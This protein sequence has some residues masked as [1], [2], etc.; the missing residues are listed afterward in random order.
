[1]SKSRV[2]MPLQLRFVLV[3]FAAIVVFLVLAPRAFPQTQSTK[4]SS[5]NVST[6]P[7]V[8]RNVVTGVANSVAP[9]FSLQVYDSGGISAGQVAVGDLN[10]DGWLDLAVADSCTITWMSCAGGGVVAVFL[11]GGGGFSGPAVYSSGGNQTG[12]VVMSDVNQDGKLDVVVYS[13]CWSVG[14]TPCLTEGVLMGNGDGSLEP[15]M[16]YSG[17]VT[18]KSVSWSDVP[19]FNGDGILDA[20]S[21][22]GPDSPG[23]TVWVQ[24]GNPD[25]TFQP[26]VGYSSGGT[27]AIAAVVVDVNGDGY[28]DILALNECPN[29]S[30]C[31]VGSV[32]VLI[33]NGDGTFQ[34]TIS[35]STGGAGGNSI[36]TADLN[37]DNKPDIVVGNHCND[38]G[39]CPT[40]NGTI[41]VLFNTAAYTGTAT[42]LVSSRNPS[43]NGAVVTFTA[44]VRPFTGNMPDGELV[45]FK[46]GNTILGTAP[47]SGG[48][49]SISTKTL[50]VGTLNITAS[51]AF[52]GI[53]GASHTQISQ[54]VKAAR[55]YP[56]ALSLTATPNPSY[57]QPVTFTATVT[58]PGGMIPNGELV[59]FYD[60]TAA[61]ATGATASGVARFVSTL[62]PLVH[63]IKAVYP[64]D[65]TFNASSGVVTEEAFGKKTMLVLNSP[66]NPTYGQ[67]V[68]FWVMVFP[69]DPLPPP[70]YNAPPTGTIKFKANG[71][72]IGSAS[73]SEINVGTSFASFATSSLNADTFAIEAVY[74]GDFIY[75]PTSSVTNVVVQQ[76]TSASTLTSS[77]NPSPLGQPVTLT[78]TVT[79]QTVVPKGPVTF[80]LGTTTLG[81]VQ[82]KG[83]V[84]HLTISSLPVGRN[85][86]KATY[87]GD[88]NIAST[89]AS[90]TQIVQ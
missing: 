90:V 27:F 30:P 42:T 29:N 89:K 67:P 37:R 53:Y 65:T 22:S 45:T 60:G 64:G 61:I 33:N 78:F 7:G 74:S 70:E 9:A 44:T 46:N 21:V 85:W 25:G 41:G 19:D 11:N 71:Y 58:S 72:A 48:G 59:T 77:M 26:P 50:P 1:M 34:P 75:A 66:G 63:H 73:L 57:A 28:P 14:P 88:S 23:G 17:P 24:L 5:V 87:A 12:A 8:R 39:T 6:A 16:P 79:S 47:L 83:G 20:V 76:A 51:Y 15:V 82:L 68:T 69:E 40:G 32:G 38:Q 10:G 18:S 86:I 62:L 55:A 31:T 56:T 43:S 80:S 2:L 54:L 84:A 3:A 52:D 81:T 36:T 4:Q 49:A 13:G 35:F